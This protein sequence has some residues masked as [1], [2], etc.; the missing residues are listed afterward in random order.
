[1]TT[2]T[3]T[4]N[5]TVWFAVLYSHRENQYARFLLTAESEEAARAT[6]LEGMA[7]GWAV[8]RCERMCEA[9]PGTDFF[10]EV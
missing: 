8:R 7:P 3:T 10:R 2:T 5:P 6:V 1:M 9:A 4:I